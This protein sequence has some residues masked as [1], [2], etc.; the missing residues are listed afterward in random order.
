MTDIPP[1]LP[2][3]LP[4]T[5]QAV[6]QQASVREALTPLNTGDPVEAFLTEMMSVAQETGVLD[7]AFQEPSIEDQADL[8]DINANPLEFLNEEQI[9]RL[10]QLF[11]AIPEQQRVEIDAELRKVLPPAAMQQWDAA[12]RFG[13]QRMTGQ[14]GPVV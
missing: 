6:P 1:E 11:L 8:Q 12:I 4:S 13:Q 3:E 5:Q 10:V 7:E 14:Q 9:T 2:P